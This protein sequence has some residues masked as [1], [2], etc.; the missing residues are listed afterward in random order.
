MTPI[1]NISWENQISNLKSVMSY[2][3]DNQNLLEFWIKMAKKTLKVKVNDLHSQYQLRASHDPCLVQIWWCQLK[4]V[5]MRTSKVYGQTDGWTDR[6]IQRQYPFV[7]KGQVVKADLPCDESSDHHYIHSNHWFKPWQLHIP[8]VLV[9]LGNKKLHSASRQNEF[10]GQVSHWVIRF[11]KMM[12]RP[13]VHQIHA[14]RHSYTWP[15]LR[16]KFLKSS[17]IKCSW[18]ILFLQPHVLIPIVNLLWPS[19]AI[20]WQR[21]GSTLAQVMACCLTAPSHYLNQCWLII[22]EVQRHSY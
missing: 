22:S 1:F 8:R 19:D 21:S 9:A 20:W 16:M 12:L 15:W 17:T 6:C 10:S 14:N 2:H 3:A 13:A 4:S 11:L 18:S 5:I 7:L